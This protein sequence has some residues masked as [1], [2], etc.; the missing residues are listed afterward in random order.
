MAATKTVSH[1]SKPIQ[2]LHGVVTLYGMQ[3][4]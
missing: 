4:R 3:T 1:F 2:S